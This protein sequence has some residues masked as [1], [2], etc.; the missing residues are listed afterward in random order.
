MK[1]SHTLILAASVTILSLGLYVAFSNM[2]LY[3]S[4]ESLATEM[5]GDDYSTKDHGGGGVSNFAALRQEF[6]FFKSELYALKRIG[7]RTNDLR[8][9]FIKLKREVVSLRGRLGNGENADESYNCGSN[10]AI[11]ESPPAT[12]EDMNIVAEE[13][14]HKDLKRMVFLNDVFMAESTDEQW[15]FDVDNVITQAIDQMEASK[16]N[17][18]NIQCHTTLCV[19]EVDHADSTSA[20]EFTL[21][22][23]TQVGQKLPQASYFYEQHDNGSIRVRMY[24]ARAGHDLPQVEQE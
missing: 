7:D 16:T 2:D 24:L 17:L 3:S 14:R 15:S 4:N 13:Q 23:S 8:K 1:A 19:V 20:D 12:E 6:A 22:F 5:S 18:S 9:E 11:S 21:R 10:E